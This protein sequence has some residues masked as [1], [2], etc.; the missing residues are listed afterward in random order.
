MKKSLLFWM[1]AVMLMLT[2]CSSD[3]DTLDNGEQTVFDARLLPGCWVV[4]KDGVQQNEGVWFSNE[5][6][7]DNGENK[8]AK[9]WWRK[10]PTDNLHRYETTY[11]STGNNGRISIWMWEGGRR[12]T[13]LT[14]NRL[15]IEN[16]YWWMD[17]DVEIIEYQRMDSNPQ[18]IENSNADNVNSKLIVGK[19]MASHHSKKPNSADTADM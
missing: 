3:D 9:Y 2:G 19:W 6:A 14:R 5:P 7:F 10:D 13:R 17:S 12:V 11:W 16:W 18:I 1:G 8:L 15:T 4:V